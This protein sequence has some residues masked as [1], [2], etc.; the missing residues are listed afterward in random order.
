MDEQ[1]LK[2]LLGE[3]AQEEIGDDMNLWP[4][5]QAE[6]QSKRKRNASS[7]G[8][9][10]FLRNVAAA[11]LVFAIAGVIYAVYQTNLSDP[12]IPADEITMLNLEDTQDGVTV[13]LNWAY[14]DEHRITVV[15]SEEYSASLLV[16]SATP[17]LQTTDGTIIP[18]AFGGGGGGGGG[19]ED[20]PIRGES[21]LSYDVSSLD[22]SDVE[23]LDLILTLEYDGNPPMRGGGGGG[24]GGTSSDAENVPTALPPTVPPMATIDTSA[25]VV[26]T[27]RFEFSVPV[28]PAQVY[29]V[30]LQV[31][32][33][34][35][36]LEMSELRVTPSMT[37]FEVCS[38]DFT[39][40]PITDETWYPVAIIRTDTGTQGIGHTIN[41]AALL[42]ER[43]HPCFE[44]RALL[45][46]SDAESFTVEIP[47]LV[48][49][50]IDLGEVT[51]EQIAEEEAFFAEMGIEVELEVSQYGMGTRNLTVTD[52]PLSQDAASMLVSSLAFTERLEVG[53]SFRA[54]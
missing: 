6:L 26:P 2:Q 48:R 11:M 41:S 19:G 33:G 53:A 35:I 4:E 21:M 13:T 8:R 18:P 44:M 52:S 38:V 36:S 27:F 51:P 28:I 1:R 3:I 14:A 17:T 37:K 32:T 39:I 34:S 7:I 9:M 43:E 30:E 29:D 15:W 24:G 49:R 20:A 31:M 12:S 16:G 54:E 47:Y 45:D 42:D 50:S 46:A 25:M 40:E 5:L 22:L 10:R 23:T